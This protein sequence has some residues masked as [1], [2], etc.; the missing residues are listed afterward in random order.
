MKEVLH[1]ME[2]TKGDV[3]RC[4]A[5][6]KTT[7]RDKPIIRCENCTK[8]PDEIGQDVRF[9]VCSVCKTKLKFEVHYCSQY[10]VVLQSRLLY[11]SLMVLHPPDPARKNTGQFTRR[12]VAKRK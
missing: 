4:L 9:M 11:N 6:V 7:L 3:A 2:N 1:L 10:V 12:L 8:T 5:E